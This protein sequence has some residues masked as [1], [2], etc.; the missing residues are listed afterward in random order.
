MNI[1]DKNNE[2]IET[3]REQ[4]YAALGDY[5][6]A[7]ILHKK[8]PNNNEYERLYTMSSAQVDSIDKNVFIL[9]IKMD[10][11]LEKLNS[12]VSEMDKNIKQKKEINND[13]KSKLLHI[14]GNGNGSIIMNENSKELYKYQYVANW[15]VFLGIFLISY[16]L[17]NVFKNNNNPMGK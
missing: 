2:K 7:Y 15:I 14:E 5:K 12:Y 16:S 1:V 17:Y 13:L 3:Y 11:D 10:N 9:S 6:N 8:N 4:F